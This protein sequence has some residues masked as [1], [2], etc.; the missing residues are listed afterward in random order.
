[1]VICVHIG[2]RTCAC[3]VMMM[4]AAD[5][6]RMLCALYTHTLKPIYEIQQS[7]HSQ[8]NMYCHR[9]LVHSLVH[10]IHFLCIFIQPTFPYVRWRICAFLKEI[11]H[12]NSR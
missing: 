6:L 2:T 1:M 7:I 9:M 8:S 12:Q 5:F 3:A 4:T 11:L 10:N